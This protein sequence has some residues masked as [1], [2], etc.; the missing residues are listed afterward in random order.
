MD[1]ATIILLAAVVVNLM[2]TIGFFLF[3]RN[4]NV[5]VPLSNSLLELK[6]ELISKQMEGLVSLRASLDNAHQVLNER[7]SDGNRS[8]DQKLT[9][10]SEIENKLGQLSTQ[11]SNLEIIGKNI[12]SLSDILKPP[13]MRGQFGEILLENLLREILPEALLE[14][15]YPFNDGVRVD[16]VIKLMKKLLP[17]DSKFPL[18]SFHRFISADSDT[19]EKK[20]AEKEFTQALKRHIDAIAVKYLKPEEQTTDFAVMYLPSE[21]VY[22]QMLSAEHEELFRYALSKK[23]IPSSPGHLY[24]FLASISAIYAEAGLSTDSRKFVELLTT[25]QETVSKLNDI[26]ERVAGSLRSALKNV[27]KSK[28]ELTIVTQHIQSSLEPDILENYE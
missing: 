27:D 9:V 11:T 7:L 24:G 12:Q 14:F 20:K 10:I 21:A 22:N 28:E 26:N 5:E 6:S 15:Q 18:E 23:V 1:V 19:E 2:L 25:V 13:K 8:I 16:V 4:R 3:L 17:I